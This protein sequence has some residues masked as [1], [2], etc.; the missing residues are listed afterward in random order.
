MVLPTASIA[1]LIKE[2]NSE[3][4]SFVSTAGEVSGFPATLLGAF[5]CQIPA[6]SLQAN[7]SNFH[8]QNQPTHTW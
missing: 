1:D 2:N 6:C 4:L 3:L 7:N 5:P 8:T